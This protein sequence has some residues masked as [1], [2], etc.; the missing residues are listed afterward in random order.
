VFGETWQEAGAR[1]VF[2]ETG[3]TVDAS[4]VK[5]LDIVTVSSGNNLVF[6]IVPHMQIPL[7]VFTG[8]VPNNETLEITVTDEPIQLAFPTHT[9]VLERY[10][11]LH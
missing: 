1:E 4:Q 5:L 7:D 6:G 2:E 10:F 9:E 3:I 11:N 8:F